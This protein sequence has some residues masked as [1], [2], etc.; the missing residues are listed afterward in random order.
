[1]ESKSDKPEHEERQMYEDPKRAQEWE[2]AKVPPVQPETEKKK[3][4]VKTATKKTTG[5]RTSKTP[6][7]KASTKRV[8]AAAKR[9]APKKGAKKSAVKK[10]WSFEYERR[11]KQRPEDSERTKQWEAGKKNPR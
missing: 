6:T 10:A 7:K 9:A 5:K 11:A 8:V 3:G 4:Q 2:Q 1:M